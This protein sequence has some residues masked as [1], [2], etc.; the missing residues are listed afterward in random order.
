M[1]DSIL[2]EVAVRYLPLFQILKQRVQSI[3]DGD[4]E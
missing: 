4:N 2:E 3:R 1:V